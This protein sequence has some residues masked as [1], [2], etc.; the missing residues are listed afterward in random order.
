MPFYLSTGEATDGTPPHLLIRALAQYQAR[1]ALN[2]GTAITAL[3]DSTGGTADAATA[4][5]RLFKPATAV[6]GAASGS[7]L[8][9]KASTETALGA[10]VDGVAEI[11]AKAN[12]MAARLG[13]GALTYNG[14]GA[15]PDDTLAAVSNAVTGAT[16]GAV[17]ADF[18]AVVAALA[19]AQAAVA[20]QVSRIARACGVP[21]TSLGTAGW[22]PNFNLASGAVAALS[23]ATGTAASPGVLKTEADA[24]LGVLR[25]NLATMAAVLNACRVQ[26]A[27][28]VVA[29]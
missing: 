15:T 23:T 27:P 20:H 3:T 6:G 25:N 5:R 4:G 13:L 14:G 28:A 22:A 26:G 12:A 9:G 17:V 11:A 8:A 24:A 19:D 16:T 2:A 7:N 18:N 21:A 10:A 29:I 1:H